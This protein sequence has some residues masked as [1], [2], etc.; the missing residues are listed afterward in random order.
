[1]CAVLHHGTIC[2]SIGGLTGK[3]GSSLVG[4]EF[5]RTVARLLFPLPLSPEVGGGVVF[6][7]PAAAKPASDTAGFKTTVDE[8]I[9][10]IPP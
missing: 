2:L 6:G 7:G 1:M 9:V 5:V 10:P 3:Q 4:S 8:S